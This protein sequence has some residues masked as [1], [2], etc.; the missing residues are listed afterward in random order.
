M[1]KQPLRD[2]FLSIISKEIWE[3]TEIGEQNY[4]RLLP[5]LNRLL[6]DLPYLYEED[7]EAF[8][9]V[10]SRIARRMAEE[11]EVKPPEDTCSPSEPASAPRKPY[12]NNPE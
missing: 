9:Q 10:F 2:E 8:F 7:L 11:R 4:H 6:E 12:Y 5:T 3:A 1:P